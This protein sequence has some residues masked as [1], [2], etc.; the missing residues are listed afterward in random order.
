M[1]LFNQRSVRA[2][3]FTINFC[4]RSQEWGRGRE[5]EREIDWSYDDSLHQS[6]HSTVT[7]SLCKQKSE[8]TAFKRRRNRPLSLL[9]Q[10]YVYLIE[11]RL[12]IGDRILFGSVAVGRGESKYIFIHLFSAAVDVYPHGW[13]LENPC[14]IC[15]RSNW[16]IT[17]FQLSW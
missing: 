15:I 16:R 17:G 14:E 10:K 3:E 11:Y 9:Q 12:I 7:A 1:P 2:T 6:A 4:W 13:Y 5:T 8:K